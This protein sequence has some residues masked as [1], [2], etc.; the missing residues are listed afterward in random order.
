MSFFVKFWGVRGSIPTPGHRTRVYGGNTSCV[1]FRINNH[2]FICDAGTGIRELGDELQRRE[3]VESEFHMFFSHSHWDHIQ[4]FPFFEAVYRKGKTINVYGV[5]NTDNKSHA[6]LSGQMKSDYFPVDFSEL[7][8]DIVSKPLRASGTDIKGVNVSVLKQ[9]HP[10][11]CYAFK[12]TYDGMSA[13]YATDCE[14]DLF[15]NSGK[16][17]PEERA[18]EDPSALRILPEDYIA[19]F[20]GADLVILDSQYSDQEYVDKVGWGHPRFTTSVDLA[21]Q[22]E[23]KRLALFHHD[24][25]HSDSE[26]DGIVDQARARAKMHGSNFEIFA[27]RESLELRLTNQEYELPET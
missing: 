1:E 20:K 15:L 12:F 24:P 2:L 16:F 19:F 18:A 5:E 3:N 27:A 8:A 9:P 21:V 26:I 14:L 7:G 4:G 23:V 25:D 13:I 17:G 6:L 10:G 11:G 22:A